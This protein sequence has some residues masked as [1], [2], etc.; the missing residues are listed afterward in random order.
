MN[1]R[2]VA[3]AYSI[4][5]AMIVLMSAAWYAF[6]TTNN[7]ITAE[8]TALSVLRNYYNE[9]DRFSVYLEESQKLAASQAFYQLLKDSAID[10]SQ[11]SCK[12]I[13]NVIVWSDSCHPEED[14]IRVK[15]IEDYRFSFSSL[16]KNYPN[17][18]FRPEYAN[19]LNEAMDEIISVTTP[20]TLSI[21][22]QGTFA[23]YTFNYT[24]DPTTKL[25]LTLQSIYLKD[26]E[27]LYN[28]IKEEK[29]KCSSV[30]ADCF[31]NLNFEH[32]TF[33]TEDKM[34]YLLFKFKTKGA[35]IFKE[36]ETNAQNFKP[37]E[38]NFIIEK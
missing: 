28:K 31:K 11:I 24:I 6:T 21:Q 1:K 2:A 14:F 33:T 22:K 27:E 20:F 13:E 29:N 3:F 37:I 35:F 26:F 15:F 12:I 30:S 5:I 4:I 25:N 9:Q 7:K 32:W 36:P 18:K 16:M 34:S 23:T 19:A 8:V 17:E 38:L 10:K